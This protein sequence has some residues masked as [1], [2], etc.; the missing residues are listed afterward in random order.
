MKGSKI[1]HNFLTLKFLNGFKKGIVHKSMMAKPIMHTTR[2]SYLKPIINAEPE[3]DLPGGLNF[4]KMIRRERVITISKIKTTENIQR[5]SL[6]IRCKKSMNKYL[7]NIKFS[8]IIFGRCLF[9]VHLTFNGTTAFIR[10]AI[11]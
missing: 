8:L 3:K 10:Q 7:I 4:Q 9:N 1:F 11:F 2:T 5:S 6:G